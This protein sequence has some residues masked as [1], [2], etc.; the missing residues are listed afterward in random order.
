M[1]A[2]HTTKKHYNPK[3]LRQKAEQQAFAEVMATVMSGLL[4]HWSKDELDKLSVSNTVVCAQT[5]ADRYRVGKYNLSRQQGGWNVCSISGDKVHD[6]FNK[7]AAVF[8]CLFS[9]RNKYQRAQEL[10]AED[11]QLSQL[12]GELDWYYHRLKL[13][14]EHR[15]EWRQDLYLARLSWCKPQLEQHRSN[16]QKIITS[17]KY[18]KVWENKT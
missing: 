2:S 6:F 14:V 15:D 12:Q 18:S 13:A 4:D 17:A 8:Y 9:S 1:A 3:Q 11:R 7:Q 5:G 16:M 10:L